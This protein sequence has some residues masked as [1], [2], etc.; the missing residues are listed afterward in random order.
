RVHVWHPAPVERAKERHKPLCA[1]QPMQDRPKA[2][3]LA[4][5]DMRLCAECLRAAHAML[6]GRGQSLDDPP[7]AEQVAPAAE[8]TAQRG[9]PVESVQAAARAEQVDPPALDDTRIAALAARGLRYLGSSWRGDEPVYTVAGLLSENK[10]GLK[11]VDVFIK[12]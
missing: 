3:D 12:R 5:H 8:D 7:A 1:T 10:L 2:A 11:A 9:P 4:R 6:N